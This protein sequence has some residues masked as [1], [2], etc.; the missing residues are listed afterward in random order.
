MGQLMR[1]NFTGTPSKVMRLTLPQATEPSSELVLAI[2]MQPTPNRSFAW[3]EA[4]RRLAPLPQGPP[5]VGDGSEHGAFTWEQ[6][7]GMFTVKL[8]GGGGSMEIRSENAIAVTQRLA[9]SINNFYDQAQT[10]FLANLVGG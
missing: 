3:T 5:A 9:A 1:V 4:R 7:T 8:R 6:E 2:N 10:R